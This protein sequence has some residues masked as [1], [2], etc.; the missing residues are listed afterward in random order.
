MKGRVETL[1]MLAQR[2]RQEIKF[3][4][5][6]LAKENL[7]SDSRET[8]LENIAS[9]N[10]IMEDIDDNINSCFVCCDDKNLNLGKMEVEC[11]TR[12]LELNHGS[13]IKSAVTLGVSE[14]TMI[15]KVAELKID[16]SVYGGRR[17]SAVLA[18]SVIKD[19]SLASPSSR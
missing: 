1:R 7:S 9:L 8:M 10:M 17:R 4:T 16:T 13:Q 18:E 15:R 6:D 2:F 19:D 12:A 14:R 5:Q 11:I 3:I